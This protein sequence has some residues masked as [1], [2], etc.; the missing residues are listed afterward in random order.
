M[1]QI[2][3]FKR[4]AIPMYFNHCNR[5]QDD[6][7]HRSNECIDN[8]RTY[9]NYHFKEGGMGQYRE[10]LNNLYYPEKKDD[11]ITLASCVITLPKNVREGDDKKFFES[12]YEF[13]CEDFGYENIVNAVVHMD[14]TTPHMHVGFIPALG[15]ED[16]EMTA[17]FDAKIERWKF[18]HGIQPEGVVSCRDVLNLQYFRNFHPRLY[19]YVEKSLG[20]EV[21]ILNGAT[22]GG[23]KTVLEMKNQKAEQELLKKQEEVEKLNSNITIISKQLDN[24]GIDK[25]YMDMTSLLSKL[26]VL[27]EENKAFRNLLV[28]NNIMIPRN[29]SESLKEMK[30]TYKF[31]NMTTL[32]GNF[33]PTKKCVVVETF[34][35]KERPLP[36][37]DFINNNMRLVHIV[38]NIKPKAV[39]EEEDYKTKYIVVPTDSIADTISAMYYLK[40]YEERYEALS[41]YQF[42]NDPDNL[43]REILQ[44]SKMEVEYFLNIK[45][46]LEFEKDKVKNNIVMTN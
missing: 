32:T 45:D 6:G 38:R 8:E 18:Q 9:L 27:Q 12:C 1:A 15:L 39:Y 19:N 13:L 30:S 21:E 14:E 11:V 41:L 23:N 29:V 4:P 42:S 10:R 25:K 3:K 40:Q 44:N 31:G 46:T 33:E 7:I 20:Y 28:Q 22:A 24:L 43:V 35:N 5:K 37:D 36:L 26:T 16:R 34:K 2:Q 17:K